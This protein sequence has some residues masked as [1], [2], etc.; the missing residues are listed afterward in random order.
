M[1][2]Q[3]SPAK[4]RS[5]EFTKGRGYKREEVEDF[6]D[7]IAQQTESLVKRVAELEK[8]LEE[9]GEKLKNLEGQK[10]LV[11]RTLLAAEKIK[12][13]SIASAKHEAENII[14]EAELAAKEEVKKAKDYLSILEHDFINMKEQRKEF[15][16]RLK[17]QLK[18]MLDMVDM[19]ASQDKET[20]PSQ[21]ESAPDR[22]TEEKVSD[23]DS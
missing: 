2:I 12:D 14:K 10:E 3:F 17:S 5:K 7:K 8:E 22:N 23:K 15:I 18:A 13:E 4:I 16:V 21:S 1:E 19:M 6:L 20:K 11:D 9:Q